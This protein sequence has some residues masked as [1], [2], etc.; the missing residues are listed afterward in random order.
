MPSYP[1]KVL[2]LHEIWYQGV[3]Y[4]HKF[5]EGNAAQGFEIFKAVC[6]ECH[7]IEGVGNTKKGRPLDRIYRRPFTRNH[8][9]NV[10][11]VAR[12]EQKVWDDQ[13]LD[14]YLRHPGSVINTDRVFSPPIP[15]EDRKD[16]IAF[17]KKHPWP[18]AK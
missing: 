14:K 1:G 2:Q 8:H 10:T 5:H 6:A 7:S 18:G 11:T 17:L 4:L 15:D 12:T 13:N 9:D 3:S 16:L